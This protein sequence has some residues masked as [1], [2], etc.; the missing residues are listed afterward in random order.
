[1]AVAEGFDPLASTDD[2]WAAQQERRRQKLN[3]HDV[4]PPDDRSLWVDD[5]AWSEAEL[6]AIGSRRATP[7]G[8]PSRSSPARHRQ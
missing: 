1:M 6:V 2:A 5:E 4:G 8:A 3:G 7:C